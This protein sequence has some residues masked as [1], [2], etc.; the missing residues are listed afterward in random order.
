[1]LPL[2]GAAYALGNDLDEWVWRRP[3]VTVEPHNQTSGS[4]PVRFW[5]VTMTFSN[6]RTPRDSADRKR[7][8]DQ[9]IEDPLMEP[10]KVSG[11]FV[12]YSEEAAFDRNLNPIL[13]SA[14]EPIKGKEVEFDSNR[15][16]VTVEMNLPDLD[17]QYWNALKDCV[18]SKDM[19]GVPRRC[20]KF[21]DFKW[22]RQLYGLCYFY[23][24]VTLTFDIDVRFYKYP[25]EDDLYAYRS[26][27]DRD[28]MDA[29]TMVIRG[30][31]VTDPADPDYGLYKCDP[32]I[33]DGAH[34][35]YPTEA[36]RSL[37]SNYI[38]YVDSKGNPGTVVLDGKG[39]PAQR[40]ISKTQIWLVYDI[41]NPENSFQF[42]GTCKQGL[43]LKM[44]GLQEV[45]GPYDSELDRI[46]AMFN[47]LGG[48]SETILTSC[49]EDELSP[50]TIRVERYPEIDFLGLGI[51]ASL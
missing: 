16:Q 32:D 24:T 18:N 44:P 39:M 51:P 7:C 21:S 20:V 47:L 34:P 26:G 41:I 49:S 9:K 37:T 8:G 25:Y 2:P 1:V 4:G 46:I 31:W 45:Y 35:G 15:W 38:R 30:R 42:S 14:F 28:I 19:W 50:G 10:P 11:S 5:A 40:E 12:R 23:Y 48:G 6:K 43:E 13:T 17:L 3:N 36:A 29:G 22:S 33:E 27:F